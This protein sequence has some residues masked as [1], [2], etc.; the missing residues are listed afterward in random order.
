VG[1]IKATSLAYQRS[2]LAASPAAT[3]EHFNICD[4]VNNQRLAVVCGSDSA[5][6]PTASEAL[7]NLAAL[8]GIHLWCVI[9]SNTFGWVNSSPTYS[10]II[11]LCTSQG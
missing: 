6:L 9:G 2:V 1:G 3:R 5:G 4:S 7:Q 10:I 11:L 8:V